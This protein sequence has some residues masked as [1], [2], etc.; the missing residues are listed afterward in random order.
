M[1]WP[2]CEWCEQTADGSVFAQWSI[3]DF[4]EYYAC[5][6]HIADGVKRAMYTK[7]DGATVLELYWR[8][9]SRVEELN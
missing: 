1:K 9:F 2:E 3:V 6:K 8:S 5:R 4:D 7:V